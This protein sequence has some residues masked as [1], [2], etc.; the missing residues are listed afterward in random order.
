MMRD[1]ALKSDI[2]PLRTEMSGKQQI[3]ILHV[4]S[5]DDIE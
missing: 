4:Y 5:T 3:P 1:D 2:Y